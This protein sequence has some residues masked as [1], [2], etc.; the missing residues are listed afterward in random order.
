MA[1]VRP[2]LHAFYLVGRVQF[3]QATVDQGVL[4]IK[5]GDS[6]KHTPTDLHAKLCWVCVGGTY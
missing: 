6:D 4:E 2:F 3:H 1:P 5:P